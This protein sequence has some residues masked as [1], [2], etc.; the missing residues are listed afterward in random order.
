MDIISKLHQLRKRIFLKNSVKLF[1]M[2][3][4]IDHMS[5]ERTIILYGTPAFLMVPVDGIKFSTST[6]GHMHFHYSISLTRESAPLKST[7]S[8]KL[9]ACQ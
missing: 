2:K 6:E 7:S 8:R 9:Q 1:M 3:Y 4:I 5:G